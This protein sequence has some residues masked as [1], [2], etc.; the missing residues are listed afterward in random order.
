MNEPKPQI[1]DRNKMIGNINPGNVGGKKGHTH[2]LILYS[3]VAARLLLEKET[4]DRRLALSWG[5]M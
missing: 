1:L 2:S 4:L 3:S 5:V